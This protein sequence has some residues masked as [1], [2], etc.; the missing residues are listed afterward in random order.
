MANTSLLYTANLMNNKTLQDI[1]NKIESMEEKMEL[2]QKKL[3]FIIEFFEG[4]VKKNCEKMGEHID[5]V[6]NVYENVKNPLGYLCNKIRYLSGKDERYTLT[7]VEN[8]SDFDSDEEH[9]L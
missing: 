5:F 6:E 3:D 1:N 4:D 8:N 9:L 2:I 7:N